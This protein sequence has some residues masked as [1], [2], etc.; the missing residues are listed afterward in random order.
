MVACAEGRGALL[1]FEGV[2][3]SGKST[4]SE[5]LVKRLTAEGVSYS[6][7]S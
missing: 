6:N 7:S 1:V 5:R 4:Q 2:D 3:R